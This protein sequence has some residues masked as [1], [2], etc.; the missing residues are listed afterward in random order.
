MYMCVYVHV[1][2]VALT[3]LDDMEH[4]NLMYRKAVNLDK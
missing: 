1:C 3:K 2:V 4:A